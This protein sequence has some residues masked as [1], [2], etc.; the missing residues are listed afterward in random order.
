[1]PRDANSRATPSRPILSSLSMATSASPCFPFEH[2]REHLTVVESDSEVRESQSG[3]YVARGGEDFGF[4]DGRACADAVN[5]ALVELSEAAARG[6]VCA[7]DGLNLVALEEARELVAVLRDD[8]R[9]RH[10][11]VVTQSEVG[12]ARP[13]VLA[14][15]EY[16]EDE[17]VAL[18]AVLPHQRLYVL[19]RGRLQRLEAVALVHGL[20]DADDVLAPPHVR[21][22]EVA[23]A[24]RRLCLCRH[25]TV[26]SSQ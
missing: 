6:A 5:V 26:D 13:F 22:E 20:Y 17:L 14:A 25:R 10:R 9:E 1:M 4:D 2:A 18:L 15:L 19:D 21:G 8:A 16:L 3:Q 23:H 24:A 12:L 11:Q 7:P